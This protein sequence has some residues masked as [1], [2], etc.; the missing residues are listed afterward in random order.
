MWVFQGPYSDEK[1]VNR[2]SKVW[3]DREQVLHDGH[4]QNPNVVRVAFGTGYHRVE[5]NQRASRNDL[6]SA[7]PPE[8]PT[9][10][11]RNCVIAV[12]LSPEGPG[13]PWV[14]SGGF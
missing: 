13:D 4:S 11:I 10:T 5:G 12:G 1:A 3:R 9:V 14:N 6:V 8:I 7:L 2:N